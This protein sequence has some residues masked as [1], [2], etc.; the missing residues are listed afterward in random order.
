[1]S[2][3]FKTVEI[4]TE[5]EQDIRIHPTPEWDGIELEF[6]EVGEQYKFKTLYL[7][8]QT[9]KLLIKEIN[10]MLNYI[11]NEQN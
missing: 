4:S 2:K 8:E 5:F 6:K 11:K 7:D 1:M 10:S 9:A 3:L